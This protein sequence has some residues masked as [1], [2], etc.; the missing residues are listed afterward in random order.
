MLLILPLII[1]VLPYQ[2][3]VDLRRFLP[4]RIGAHIITTKGHEFNSFAPWTGMLILCLY[5]LG[6]LVIGLALLERRDA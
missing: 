4:D 6:M 2:L 3:S 5:A 1:Q